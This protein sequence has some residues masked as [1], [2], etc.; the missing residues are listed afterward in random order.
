[1][2]RN[3]QKHSASNNV[4]FVG[5][6]ELSWMLSIVK[7]GVQRSPTRKRRRW[8]RHYT[9]VLLVCSIHVLHTRGSS[10]RGE[11]GRCFG[12]VSHVCQSTLYRCLETAWSQTRF[13]RTRALRALENGDFEIFLDAPNFKYGPAPT[14]IFGSRL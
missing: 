8:C 1:M 12:N 5:A 13:K 9:R 11:N 4:T 14:L 6:V 7:A 3:V 2:T 10:E